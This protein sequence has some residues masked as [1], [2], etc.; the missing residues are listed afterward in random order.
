VERY[1]GGDVHAYMADLRKR[2]GAGAQVTHDHRLGCRVAA[3]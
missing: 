2:Q 1:Y 3:A